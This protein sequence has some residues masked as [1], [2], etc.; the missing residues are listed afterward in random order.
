[1]RASCRR[2][3]GGAGRPESCRCAASTSSTSA[4]TC[5]P[6]RSRRATA[7]LPA[8]PDAPATNTML[9]PPAARS[10]GGRPA[11][12]AAAP[13]THGT[14]TSAAGSCMRGAEGGQKGGWFPMARARPGT[15]CY[16]SAGTMPSYTW[17]KARSRAVA[18][19]AAP[20]SLVCWDIHQQ[21]RAPTPR[22]YMGRRRRSAG[23]WPGF[24]PRAAIW[25]D[26]C[27]AVEAQPWPA[28]PTPP[29]HKSI[30]S[31]TVPCEGH[32][33]APAPLSQPRPAMAAPR[34]ASPFYT[35]TV[36][37]RPT[38]TALPCN[39]G[40][41]FDKPTLHTI[42]AP[43]L[44]LLLS[45]PQLQCQSHFDRHILA[46]HPRSSCIPSPKFLHT[47]PKVLAYH[48]R[49]SAPAPIRQHRPAVPIPPQQPGPAG[50][51]ACARAYPP[52]PTAG[53]PAAAA[54]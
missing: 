16:R 6:A 47:I 38:Q 4:R 20:M 21:R 12:A 48:P 22:I 5:S 39:T 50:C 28:M 35:I 10:C 25:Q 43:L 9:P 26:L 44:Q 11:I 1:M 40:P 24:G 29:L 13:A 53:S 37:L 34:Q 54:G 41:H 52:A 17:V 2:P 51:A 30:F 46:Y 33:T 42:I 31:P 15:W 27:S 49:S 36:F 45:Q 3:P 32:A 7:A 8:A 18:R 23:S 19:N 14:S